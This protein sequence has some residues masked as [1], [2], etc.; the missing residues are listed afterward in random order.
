MFE[1]KGSIMRKEKFQ[2]VLQAGAD[3][4]KARERRQDKLKEKFGDICSK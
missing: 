1:K 4:E 2:P 3:E